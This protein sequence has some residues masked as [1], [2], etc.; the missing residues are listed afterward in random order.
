MRRC[1]TLLLTL[2]M[3]LPLPALAAPQLQSHR[4]IYDLTLNRARQGSGIQTVQGRLV[5]EW[6]RVCDGYILNQRL[7]TETQDTEG[8][9]SVYDYSVATWESEDGRRFRFRSRNLLNGDVVDETDGTAR[10]GGGAE[11]GEAHFTKP[12]EKTVPLPADVI[13]PTEHTVRLVTAAEAGRKTLPV[14]VFDGSGIDSVYE[15]FAA[16]GPAA[17]MK[18]DSK[19]D[20]GLLAGKKGWPVTLAYFAQDAKDELP[21]FE[22]GFRLFDNGIA[23]DIHLD[24]QDFA[25]NGRLTMLQKLP[26][27]GC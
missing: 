18:T 26:P 8:E 22:I 17:A 6:S 2:L 5:L 7:L 23:G 21:E 13:F 12:E 25:L 9:V 3:L 4:A 11:P 15:T 1:S 20:V 24:Y 19:G 10:R 27:A 16:I 14:R